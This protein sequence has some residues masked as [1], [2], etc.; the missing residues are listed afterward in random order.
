[1]F[2]KQVAILFVVSRTTIAWQSTSILP[3]RQPISLSVASRDVELKEKKVSY[4]VARGDGSTGGGGLPMPNSKDDDGL[5][6]P[7]V[8]AAMP[9]G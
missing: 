3:P 7:K 1:M 5:T 6:R 2:Y 4:V 9:E 8:G